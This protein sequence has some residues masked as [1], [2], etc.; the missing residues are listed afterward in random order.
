MYTVRLEPRIDRYLIADPVRGEIP[1]PFIHELAA[2]DLACVL[3]CVA[4]CPPQDQPLERLQCDSP[5]KS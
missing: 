4:T 5:Y 2:K 3:N 1:I